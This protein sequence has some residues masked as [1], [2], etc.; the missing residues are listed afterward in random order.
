[1]PDAR[2]LVPGTWFT[3]V[4]RRGAKQ[5]THTIITFTS[6]GGMVER[7]EPRVEA[8]IGV[9]EPGDKEDEFRT[10]RYRFLEDLKIS[11]TAEEKPGQ[12]E[13]VEAVTESF[14]A[15]QRVRTTFRLT[16][17]DHF[18]GTVTSDF[19]DAAEVPLPV[20]ASRADSKGERL[21]LVREA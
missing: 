3:T 11:E 12:N 8:S 9:W 1:M 5:V 21:T 2:R 14:A 17:D 13:E 7:A 20:P 6:D 18:E 19:L 16:N 10:M 4:R 15:I